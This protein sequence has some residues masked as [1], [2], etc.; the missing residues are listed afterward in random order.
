VIPAAVGYQ[1][2]TFVAPS[3]GQARIFG[4]LNSLVTF[5]HISAIA[6]TVGGFRSDH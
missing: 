2:L 1:E 4:E 3:L 5:M 6:C